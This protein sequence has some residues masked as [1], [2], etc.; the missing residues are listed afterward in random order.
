MGRWVA[1]AWASQRG[2]QRAQS[3]AR[4]QA[5]AKAKAE[6]WQRSLGGQ[7]ARG[8]EGSSDSWALYRVEVAWKR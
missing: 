4:T 2:G 3:N 5:L 1:D 8:V 7:V 6:R